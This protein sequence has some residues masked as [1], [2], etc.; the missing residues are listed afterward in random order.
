MKRIRLEIERR[1]NDKIKLILERKE[2]GFILACIAGYYNAGKTTLF[3]ALTYENKPVSDLPFTTLS[4]K[5]SKMY[6]SERILIIDTIGFVI[7]LDPRIIKS[8]EINI[9]DLRYSDLIILTVDASD[10]SDWFQIKAETIIRYLREIGALTRNKEL[11][12]ALNKI[13]LL[14]SNF[15]IETKKLQLEHILKKHDLTSNATIVPISAKNGTNIDLLVSE[16]LSK[17]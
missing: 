7:D 12:I 15:D 11:I 14:K 6:G 2:R 8:F 16:M 17:I 3:N 9:E 5:Y 13:D 4:S 10:P 1:R